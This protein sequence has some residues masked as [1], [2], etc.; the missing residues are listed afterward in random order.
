MTTAADA[1]SKAVAAN[2]NKDVAAQL[3]FFMAKAGVSEEA[4]Q[5]IYDFGVKTVEAYGNLEDDKKSVRALLKDEIK[6]VGVMEIGLLVGVWKSCSDFQ[7]RESE[8]VASA[9]AQGI[10]HSISK[11]DHSLMRQ[12]YEA[13]LGEKLAK[14]EIPSKAMLSAK[15]DEMHSGEPEPTP[16][17]EVAHCAEPEIVVES[18]ATDLQG[19]TRVIKKKVKG[20]KPRQQE[21]LRQ[22][23]TIEG[24]AWCILAQKFTN[25]SWLKDISIKD[26]RKMHRAGI[27]S[28]SF[29]VPAG[30]KERARDRVQISIMAATDL[31]TGRWERFVG[32]H[33]GGFSAEK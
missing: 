2:E 12:A 33:R 21:E 19:Y 28:A 22:K 13:K 5:K 26:K 9:H 17:D 10:F 11:A 25:A 30:A 3:K 14:E 8:A 4:Q 7:E 31:Q 15:L 16:L 23:L 1:S 29:L 20:T 27:K 18:T 6:V 32:P 24:H